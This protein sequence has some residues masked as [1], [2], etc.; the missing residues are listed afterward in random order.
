MHNMNHPEAQARAMVPADRLPGLPELS[1][2]RF[3]GGL[4]A[5]VLASR[6]GSQVQVP[7]APGT[8]TIELLRD[9]QF[10]QGL[11]VLNIEPGTRNKRTN[12]VFNGRSIAGIIRPAGATGQPPWYA[13]QWYSHFNLAEARAEQLPSGSTR[14]FD[15]AKTVTF[16]CSGGPE[17]D[18][19]L[20]LNGRTEWGDVVPATQGAWPH[21]L[22]QQK[23]LDNPALPAFRS[24]R[25][26]ISY[27]LLHSEA[28]RGPGW[29]DER[30]TAH[31]VVFLTVQNFNAQS[32]GFGDYLWFG[33]P[34]WDGRYP[35]PQRFVAR[36]AGNAQKRGTG[37]FIFN[38]GGAVYTTEE[39]GG[40]NWVT[41]DRDVLPLLRE[42]LE[43]AWSAGYLQDSHN[44]A[45]YHLGVINMG[46]EITGPWDAA[47][48]VRD[49]MLTPVVAAES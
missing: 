6:L 43:T 36:D 20:A 5:L 23:L 30:H 15:G 1:R 37:K 2:R 25:F 9:A 14:F 40:G 38:P 47:M 29:N 41:I 33:V 34:L 46:W 7:P 48:Q 3:L 8:K 35:L 13:A 44:A 42:A 32:G 45:D 17:A 19:V 4:G 27:R 22:V 49:L 10:R 12:D 11:S 26:Q 21:L 16:G 24:L 31:F 39:A 18:L 28:H